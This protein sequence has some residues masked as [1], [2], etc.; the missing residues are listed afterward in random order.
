MHK[1]KALP[2]LEQTLYAT[3]VNSLSPHIQNL[4]MSQESLRR[5]LG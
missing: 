1:S 3:N 4:A 5:R 2:T